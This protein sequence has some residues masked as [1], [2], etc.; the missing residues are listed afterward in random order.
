MTSCTVIDRHALVLRRDHYRCKTCGRP[1][2]TVASTVGGGGT[3]AE[4]FAV[5]F[6]LPP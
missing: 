6:W 3:L 2:D 1:A 4:Q 5:C